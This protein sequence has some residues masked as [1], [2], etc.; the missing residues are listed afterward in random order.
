[1]MHGM[2]QQPNGE[3]TQ[4]PPMIWVPSM[5]GSGAAIAAHLTI[6]TPLSRGQVRARGHIHVMQESYES[7]LISELGSIFVMYGATRHSSFSAAMNVFVKHAEEA[8]LKAGRDIIIE[9]SV[10]NSHLEAG[11][12][13]I[14]E[15][16]RGR[17][18]G[19]VL[20]AQQQIE[21]QALGSAAEAPTEVNVLAED[22]FIVC[23]NVYPGVSV[24]IGGVRR[25]FRKQAAT[26]AFYRKIFRKEKQLF[27][28]VV[29]RETDGDEVR[30]VPS[31]RPEPLLNP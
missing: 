30:Y 6:E 15:S 14:S 10:R 4:L 17:A 25:I 28:S 19:G 24:T 21:L 1:M 12:K 29:T 11:R 22:G 27:L 2:S 31:G 3:L 20:T 23:R 16:D 8:D 5:N 9:E 18:V 7:S 13:I 26:G